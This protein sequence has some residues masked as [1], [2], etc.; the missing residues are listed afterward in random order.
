MQGSVDLESEVVCIAAHEFK[1]LVILGHIDG[2]VTIYD[3]ALSTI[4]G[5]LS[6]DISSGCLI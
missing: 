5:S 6:S 4:V 3:F 2:K 1:P